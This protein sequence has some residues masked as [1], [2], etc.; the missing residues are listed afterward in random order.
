MKSYIYKM[1]IIIFILSSSI[2]AY[3][4][5]TEERVLYHNY[6]KNNIYESN[7]PK[8]RYE[9]LI[10]YE[11]LTLKEL[12]NKINNV[13][14]STLDGYGTNIAS[15]ALEYEV[16]PLVAT[17]IILV[18]TGCKW[19][20]SYLTKHCNNIGGMKGTGCGSYASFKD[21]DTGLNAFIRNLANNYYAYGLTTP[22]LMNKKYAEN[23][24]WYK[25]VNYY[26]NLIKA[27]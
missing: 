14:N 27:S 2:I 26:I 16:D 6:I 25:D 8:S 13:L 10:V 23:P 17:G 1:M 11:G 24:N 18:E 12:S 7:I 15:I 19:N 4:K 21:L 3:K 20:C 22:E 5:S 9:E